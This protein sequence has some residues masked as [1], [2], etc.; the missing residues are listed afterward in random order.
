MSAGEL[1]HEASREDGRDRQWRSSAS[2]RARVAEFQRSRLLNAATAIACEHGYEGMTATA[3]VTRA[4]ASRKT[5]Y[6]L[7]EDRDDCFLAVLD[8]A[9]AQIA[10]AVVPAYEQGRRWEERVRAGLVALL[11]FLEREHDLG[12]LV[13]VHGVGYAPGSMGLRER[14]LERLWDVVEGGRSETAV[15]REPSPVTGEAVVGGVLAVILTRLQ[16]DPRELMALVNPLMWMIVLPYR[17]SA[18]A[19]RQLRRAK[20]SYAEVPPAPV[21]EP[22]RELN[23]RLTYRTARV[24]EAIAVAPAVNN[25]QIAAQVDIKDQGQISKLLSR[26]ARLG[27][28]ENR[29][30]GQRRGAANAWH[31]TDRGIELESAIRR[32]AAIGRRA[33]QPCRPQPHR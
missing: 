9:L 33:V 29:G 14:V 10:D 25:A 22:L 4:G 18:A 21:Q 7:F 24:L 12:L 20:P 27:L 11:A 3:V 28:I 26:L 32:K 17:G 6:S 23:M 2:Q 31:L 1:D 15:S 5:F 16:T 30:A 8:Q 19:A 13:L